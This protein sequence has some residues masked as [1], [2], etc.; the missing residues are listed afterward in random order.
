MAKNNFTRLFRYSGLLSTGMNS[1]ILALLLLV[2][3]GCGGITPP[4]DG[5]TLQPHA[6]PTPTPVITASQVF[7]NT[8]QTWN[9]TDSF[10][11]HMTI[12]PSPI[13]CAFGSCG[14]ITVWHYTKDS[15]LGY[16]NNHTPE[17]CAVA[18]SLDELYFV[19]RHDPDGAWR[20]IG[21]TYL[22][23]LSVKR[24]I[25]FS[26]QPGKALPYTVIPASSGTS[27]P[28]TAYDAQIQT[29]D[30]NADLTDFSDPVGGMAFSSSWRTDAS[31]ESGNLISLQHEGC[32][33][34]KWALLNGLEKVI[35]V[36]GLGN[37]GVCLTMDSGLTMVRNH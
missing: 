4:V 31:L 28:N 9:F 35:P 15:C 29:L 30:F 22:D 11:H 19:L 18:T 16:W 32:I 34:E 24:K 12:A 13:A 1:A 10:N 14:D 3:A 2:L 26:Q 17:Q 6:A 37:N 21:L 36:V 7:T 8:A 25:K 5:S 27:D 33:T 23:Y 20:C